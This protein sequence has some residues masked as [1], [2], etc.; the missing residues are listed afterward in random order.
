MCKY[1]DKGEIH[2]TF[3]WFLYTVTDKSITL[4]LEPLSGVFFYLLTFE[5][6]NVNPVHFLLKYNIKKGNAVNPKIMWYSLHMWKSI[7][8]SVHQLVI[9]NYC[10]TVSTY[11]TSDQDIKCSTYL[12]FLK[13]I[14]RIVFDIYVLLFVPTKTNCLINLKNQFSSNSHLLSR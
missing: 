12:L 7:A 2:R 3:P 11:S 9:L 6:L 8:F 14:V 13:C 4:V 1:C 5:D 10:F